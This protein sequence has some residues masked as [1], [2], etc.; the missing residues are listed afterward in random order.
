MSYCIVIFREN[1]IIDFEYREKKTKTHAEG[2]KLIHKKNKQLT[3][4]A[5]AK[6]VPTKDFKSTMKFM[7]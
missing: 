1:Q 5:L 2:V 7:G 6:L 3:V 4:I